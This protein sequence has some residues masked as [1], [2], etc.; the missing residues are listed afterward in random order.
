MS[1]RKQ[2]DEDFFDD[3]ILPDND[4]ANLTEERVALGRELFDLLDFVLLY[5]RRLH[6]AP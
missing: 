5:L 3:L 2:R 4:F 1:L 6:A